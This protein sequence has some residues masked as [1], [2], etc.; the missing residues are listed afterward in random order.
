[1]KITPSGVN[2]GDQVVLSEITIPTWPGGDYRLT[3]SLKDNV[4]NSEV[5]GEGGLTIASKYHFTGDQFKE[6]IISAF[7]K[8]NDSCVWYLSANYMFSSPSKVSEVVADNPIGSQFDGYIH[9]CV[10]EA[11]WIYGTLSSHLDT[12]W[13][14]VAQAK[15]IVEDED[16]QGIA[17]HRPV[18]GYF[19]E[20][21]VKV[22]HRT[23]DLLDVPDNWRL[24]MVWG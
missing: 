23:G 19:P 11:E 2:S 7:M 1:M 10:M 4:G 15:V 12:T 13:M 8:V 3:V 14:P 24:L 5:I 22:I 21:G 18:I 20:L 16:G 9:K 6:A 17:G